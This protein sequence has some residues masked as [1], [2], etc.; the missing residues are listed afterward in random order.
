MIQAATKS[1]PSIVSHAQS[2][3]PDLRSSLA[4]ERDQRLGMCRL[5]ASLWAVGCGLLCCLSRELALCV[6]CVNYARF[7]DVSYGLY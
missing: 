3:R 2:A 1:Y 6:N 4:L 7:T 5:I